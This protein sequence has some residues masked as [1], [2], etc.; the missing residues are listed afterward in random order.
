MSD[1]FRVVRSRDGQE[2]HI[3]TDLVGACVK[4]VKD[5][6][7]LRVEQLPAGGTI[8]QRVVPAIECCVA[9]KKWLPTNPHF[10]SDDERK[11]MATFIREACDPH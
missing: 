8:A 6:K 5:S 10:I 1:V 2:V 9:L 11:D 3:C 7:E 4:W